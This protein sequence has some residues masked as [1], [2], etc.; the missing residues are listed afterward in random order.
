MPADII[1]ERFPEGQYAEGQQVKLRC[2]E[3]S[4]NSFDDPSQPLTIV[5]KNWF[6][7]YEQPVYTL[8]VPG[9]AGVTPFRDADLIPA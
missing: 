3:A 9:G 2:P 6:R 7:T 1:P 8:S 5:S 4:L